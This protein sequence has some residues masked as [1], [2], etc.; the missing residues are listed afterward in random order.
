MTLVGLVVGQT[1]LEFLDF[2]T[3]STIIDF[4]CGGG[5]LLGAI[6]AKQKIGIEVNGVAATEAAKNGVG[7]LPWMM[8][9]IILL[10][11]LFLIMLLD[12]L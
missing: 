11:L 4:G 6:E 3:N 5:Y 12:T 9:Q 10:T 1:K 2:Q 7:F 8:S